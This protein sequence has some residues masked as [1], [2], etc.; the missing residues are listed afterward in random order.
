MLALVADPNAYD[1]KVVAIQ[2]V[3]GDSGGTALIFP[4][5]R[6]VADGDVAS[7]VVCRSSNAG[8]CAKL[9]DHRATFIGKFSVTTPEDNLFAPVGSLTLMHVR[10]ARPA[11]PESALR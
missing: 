3:V 2:G 10:G 9:R 6:F 7:A 8:S 4:N 1:G 5:A 11:A